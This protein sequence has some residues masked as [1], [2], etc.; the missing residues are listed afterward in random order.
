MFGLYTVDATI[1]ISLII[2]ALFGFKKGI[3]KGI[4]SLGLLIVAIIAAWFLKNPIAAIMYT[5]LPFISFTS[6]TSI[7]N[8]IIYE[9]IAFLIIAIILL[10]IVKLIMFFTGLID[11]ILSLTKVMGFASRILGLIFG[12]IETYIFIFIGLFLMYNFTNFYKDIDNN[13][14]ALRMLNST[15]ILSP[16]I[17]K[18]KGAFDEIYALKSEYKEDD[19]EYNK[20]VFEVLIKYKVISVNTAKQLVNEGKI[21]IADA[22]EIIK[23]YE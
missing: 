1:A 7:I 11:K 15:P 21:K 23:M 18:E 4:V 5:K 8:I 13:T 16:M 17:E 12:F 22:N 9:M 6:S 10:L 19:E 20:K 14:L 2:G 3:I